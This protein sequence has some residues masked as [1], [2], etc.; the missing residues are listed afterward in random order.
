MNRQDYASIGI[1]VIPLR[2][3]T[4]IPLCNAWPTL[5]I[6]L[7]WTDAPP[8]ANGGLRHNGHVLNIDADNKIVSST[9]EHVGNGLAG[10]GITATP[11]IQ[12]ASGI[13]R[14]FYVRCDDAPDGVV[15]RKLDAAVGAGELRIGVG[16]MSVL[17]PSRIDG[18]SY[19][20]LSGD[21]HA[22]P[23]VRWRDMLWLLPVQRLVTSADALPVRLLW[24][25]APRG[26]AE[27]WRAI[28]SAPR[29]TRTGKYANRSEAEAAVVTALIL[30]GWLFAEI[31][32]EFQRR[33]CGHF[34]DAGRHADKY[35][36]TTYSNALSAVMAHD[37]RQ[38][39]SVDYE[40]ADAVGWPGRTGNSDKSVYLAVLAECYRVGSVET[41]VSVREIAEHAAVS[42]DTA[43]N[44]LRRLSRDGRLQRTA[45]ASQDG[46]M[47]ATWRI[48]NRLAVIGQMSQLEACPITASVTP[49]RLPPVS[50][51]PEI[52][53][54][55]GLGKSAVSVY[56]HLDVF[57]AVTVSEL[58]RRT[59]RARS[60]VLTSLRTLAK[61]SLSIETNSGGWLA[62]TNTLESVSR[63]LDC[64]RLADERRTRHDVE[65][66]K[67]A[68]WIK[69]R[70][71]AGAR[72]GAAPAV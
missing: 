55:A 56:R 18:R 8:T 2:P 31:L 36:S 14:A 43:S 70:T 32:G 37:V 42:K 40:S 59:S 16:A 25:Y 6:T 64:I 22:M 50:E 61:Y 9:S 54:R 13:G 35:L 67:Y 58:A 29:G 63:E 48:D 15:L 65:R 47:A 72:I 19:T 1:D 44:A 45:A 26:T 28:A 71:D 33:N 53:S 41:S 68:V 62:G 39:V 24:R 69:L 52:A 30:N 38:A 3:N 23:V 27:L 49:V 60:T 7:Q 20:L 4:K 51:A 17:P 66:A 12:T 34:A 46:T 5:D 11:V 57:A 21:W 10:L